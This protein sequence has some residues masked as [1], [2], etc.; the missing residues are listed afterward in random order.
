V[1]VPELA[2]RAFRR[3]FEEHH[4]E[5]AS[6]AALLTG[7]TK[8]ADDLA[9]SA[10]AQIRID[11]ERAGGSD[12]SLTYAR[13]VL[14]AL[15][16]DWERRQRRLPHASQRP[17]DVHLALLELPYRRRVCVVLH[18][19]FG[20][21]EREIADSVGLPA[22]FIRHRVAQGAEQLAGL[23]GE[24]VRRQ[25]PMPIAILARAGVPAGGHGRHRRWGQ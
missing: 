13:G 16:R 1:V 14:I 10:L 5:L 20:L 9:A 12:G 11:W 15:V 7:E 22:A 6:L 18:Y 3:F 19:A 4:V 25:A 17:R 8:A 24:P 23:L 21:T 2:E